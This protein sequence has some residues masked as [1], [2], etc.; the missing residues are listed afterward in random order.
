MKC[1]VNRSANQ[2]TPS[3]TLGLTPPVRLFAGARKEGRGASNEIRMSRGFFE[4]KVETI[5]RKPSNTPIGDARFTTAILDCFLPERGR[6][7]PRKGLECLGDSSCFLFSSLPISSHF[8]GHRDVSISVFA[9]PCS[10]S[11]RRGCTGRALRFWVVYIGTANQ[12][13]RT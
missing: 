12:T 11:S 3:G 13:T 5:G 4:T 8:C 2:A 1:G 7:G 6:G 9:V 10:V